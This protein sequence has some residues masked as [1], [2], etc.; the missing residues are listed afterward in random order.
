MSHQPVWDAIAQRIA[1]MGDP[2][3]GFPR[4][5][6]HRGHSA[7]GIC[8]AALVWAAHAPL[9]MA[10]AIG[11]LALPAAKEIQDAWKER[12][13]SLDLDTVADFNQYQ[14]A[15][16]LVLIERQQWWPLIFVDLVIG[17]VYFITMPWSRP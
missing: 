2:V 8:I 6:Y 12:R 3:M 14:V 7:T 4:W 11:A 17:L 15:W 1:S 10:C 9:V 5:K 13:L 16:N